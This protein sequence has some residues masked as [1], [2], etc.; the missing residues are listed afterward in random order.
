MIMLCIFKE[1]KS[2]FSIYLI[3][4]SENYQNKSLYLSRDS[5]RDNNASKST[6]DNN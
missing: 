4:Y 6:V 3:I 2:Q 5:E 1:I